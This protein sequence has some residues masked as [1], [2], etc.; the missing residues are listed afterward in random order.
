MPRLG[1]AQQTITSP[2][3]GDGTNRPAT[4]ILAVAIIAL[5]A[6]DPDAGQRLAGVFGPY[7]PLDGLGR[8]HQE[9]DSRLRDRLAVYQRP[10]GDLKNPGFDGRAADDQFGEA[11]AAD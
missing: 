7:R 8:P 9:I 4:H 3:V 11:I 1:Q 10:R 6:V 5:I 2:V